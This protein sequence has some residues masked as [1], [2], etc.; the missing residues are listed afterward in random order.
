VDLLVLDPDQVRSALPMD[1]CIEAVNSALRA[2][3][4]GTSV[5]PLRPVV[6]LSGNRAISAHGGVFFHDL[7]N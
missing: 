6:K 4:R 2:R 3:A 5:Q 7:G 1:A